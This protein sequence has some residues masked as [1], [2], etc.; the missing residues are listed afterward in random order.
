MVAQ[1]AH[2]PTQQQPEGWTGR[3]QRRI[4]QRTG[5]TRLRLLAFRIGLPV[6]Q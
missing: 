1:E 3:T 6:E 5:Q 4:R 2:Q